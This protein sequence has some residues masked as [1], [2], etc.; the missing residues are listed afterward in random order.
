M[1]Q[2]ARVLVHLDA[3]PQ[4]PER[5]KIARSLTA[6][7]GGVLTVALAITPAWV[8]T[9]VMGLG[10]EMASTPI[11]ADLDRER[12]D[13]AR[14]I[15]DTEHKLAGPP[16]VWVDNGAESPERFLTELSWYHDLTV[17]GQ[18]HRQDA[19]YSGVTA[20]FAPEVVIGSGRPCLVVPR[21]APV[22]PGLRH[23]MLAWKPTRESARALWAAIPWLRRAQ[24]ITVVQLQEHPR[25]DVSS[26]FP[27]SALRDILEVQGLNPEFHE[28]PA[29]SQTGQQL[30]SLAR[31]REVDV[32]VMG[33]YGHTRA[34]EWLFGGA[35]RGVLEDMHLP[36]L[37]A[38]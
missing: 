4:A 37:M 23:V 5:L 2:F 32:L 3:S 31:L 27:P 25:R 12:R 28:A 26:L 10:G 21:F 11:L 9:P 13:Q 29:S 18:V 36:V 30:L 35:T 34:H 1:T 16:M 15:F 33:C 24:T 19:S 8:E 7:T 17:M 6:Q 22:D 20:R 38:H 14:A